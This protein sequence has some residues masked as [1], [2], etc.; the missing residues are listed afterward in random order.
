MKQQSFSTIEQVVESNPIF[1]EFCLNKGYDVFLPLASPSFQ[2]INDSSALG[3]ISS[4]PKKM[5]NYSYHIL[6]GFSD[7]A[8]ATTKVRLQYT[9]HFDAFLA[10]NGYPPDKLGDI[11]QEN[12]LHKPTVIIGQKGDRL[13]HYEKQLIVFRFIKSLYPYTH[14]YLAKG[15]HQFKA[16]KVTD[17]ISLFNLLEEKSRH[18]IPLDAICYHGL[19]VK[20]LPF[21][22]RNAYKWGLVKEKYKVKQPKVKGEIIFLSK[23]ENWIYFKDCK[24]K[25]YKVLNYAKVFPID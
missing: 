9:H 10:F 13:M 24:G 25:K 19:V 16:Y 11:E 7:G 22:F 21:N 6:S 3:I 14:F 20:V 4:I 15:R 12:I 2:W 23:D 1:I 8:T 5:P 17:F 18:C